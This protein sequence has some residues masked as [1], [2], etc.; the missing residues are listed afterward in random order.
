MQHNSNTPEEWRD[1]PGYEGAYQVSDQG[2]VRSLDRYVLAGVDGRRLLRGKPMSI[3]PDKD[4]YQKVTLYSSGQGKT[5]RVHRLV[6]KSFVGPC[7]EGME[8]CHGNGGRSDNRLDNLRWDSLSA[9]E[10]DKVGHGNHHQARKVSCPLGHDL[11]EPNLCRAALERG[12]RN[13]R[14]CHGGRSYARRHG[15]MDQLQEITD[16]LYRKIMSRG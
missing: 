3:S 16:D 12:D 4:G 6:L 8:A 13:C 5:F 1:I 9:N 15:L 10:Y 2:R 14:A 11:V 7:P